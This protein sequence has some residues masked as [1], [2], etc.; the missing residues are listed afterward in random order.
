MANE[1]KTPY[2]GTKI[3]SFDIPNRDGSTTRFDFCY[4]EALNKLNNIKDISVS[5][6]KND[7]GSIILND[8]GGV[9]VL[10]GDMLYKN[11]DNWIYHFIMVQDA[12][13]KYRYADLFKELNSDKI[14][15]HVAIDLIVCRV[16]NIKVELYIPL[17]RNVTKTILK[18]ITLTPDE[19]KAVN[20]QTDKIIKQTYD[21]LQNPIN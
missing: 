16:T 19:V 2:Y 6:P 21:A 8:T 18:Y 20:Q 15:A 4:I 13:F 9:T 11:K 7:D 3:R 1:E 17:R 10:I 5:I 14:A 12:V